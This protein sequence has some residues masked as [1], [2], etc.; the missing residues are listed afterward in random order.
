MSIEETIKAS[1]RDVKL[2]IISVK[3]QLLRLAEE[4]KELRDMI[5]DMQKDSKKNSKTSSGKKK[6]KKKAKK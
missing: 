6:A 5:L 4:Q 1:F 2:D 3:G